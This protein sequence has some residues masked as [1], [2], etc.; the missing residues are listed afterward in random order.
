MGDTIRMDLHE[1]DALCED[2][3]RLSGDMEEIGA[4]LRLAQY[5][6][7]S[8]A[9]EKVGDELARS[10]RSLLEMSERSETAARH[11]LWSMEQFA[12]CEQAEKRRFEEQLSVLP[13][14]GGA[15]LRDDGRRRRENLSFTPKNVHFV[16]IP[17]SGG[18]K[19]I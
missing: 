10:R 2:L 8:A 14:Y 11:I 13:A 3:R 12:A 7:C 6:L 15:F 18:D 16:R 19:R 9:E 17:V 4:A 1:L 5:R